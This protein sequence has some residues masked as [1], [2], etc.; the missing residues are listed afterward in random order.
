MSAYLHST[1]LVKRRQSW[2][3]HFYI[4]YYINVKITPEMDY[5]Y[6]RTLIAMYYKTMLNVSIITYDGIGV[7][8]AI[9]D[10]SIP[11]V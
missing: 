8:V 5:S 2:I 3:F 6:L 11:H 4:S 7:K 9:L 10:F 1:E